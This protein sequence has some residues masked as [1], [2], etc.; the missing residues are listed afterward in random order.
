MGDLGVIFFDSQILF[1]TLM[2]IVTF[3]INKEKGLGAFYLK[4]ELY[5]CR[6]SSPVI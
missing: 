3:E 1:N 6:I 5:Q 4:G 2:K